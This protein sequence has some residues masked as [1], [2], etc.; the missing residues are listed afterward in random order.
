[1]KKAG[2]KI[3]FLLDPAVVVSVEVERTWTAFFAQRLRWAGKMRGLGGVGLLTGAFAVLLPYSIAAVTVWAVVDFRPGQGV[4][5]T[6]LLLL[7]AWGLWAFSVV[8]LINTAKRAIGAR[9]R[10]LRSLFA[11]L[12]F[13]VYSLPIAIA[14]FFVRSHWKGRRI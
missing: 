10:S 9:R 6:W 2:K 3:S 12:C 13:P 11:L 7:A 8:A 4:E 5:R 1:M 14:S